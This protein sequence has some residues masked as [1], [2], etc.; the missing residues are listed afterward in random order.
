MEWGRVLLAGALV[1]AG[2]VSAQE[3]PEQDA[4]ELRAQ[5]HASLLPVLALRTRVSL[6][7]RAR[8]APPSA[9]GLALGFTGDSIRAHVRLR[10]GFRY[11]LPLDAEADPFDDGVR[12]TSSGWLAVTAGT[13]AWLQLDLDGFREI[14]GRRFMRL[15]AVPGLRFRAADSPYEAGLGALASLRPSSAEQFG[16]DRLAAMIQISARF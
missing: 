4:L 3:Q 7:D 11:G 6:F 13:V 15:D 14:A 8:S 16:I 10:P 9:T 5:T 2:A 1:C 12:L